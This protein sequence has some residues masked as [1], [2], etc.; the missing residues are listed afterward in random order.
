[1]REREILYI[2]YTNSAARYSC[3]LAARVS[4]VTDIDMD[5]YIRS[6]DI[7]RGGGVKGGM[8]K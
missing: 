6:I 7:E 4:D 8:G 2:G 5:T 3:T 1:V